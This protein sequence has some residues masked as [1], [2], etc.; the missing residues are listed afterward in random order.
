MQIF[1]CIHFTV[2]HQQTNN[3]PAVPYTILRG[4]IHE[5]FKTIYYRRHSLCPDHRDTSAF[6]IQLVRKQHHHRS[7]YANQR[8]HMG[9]YEIIIFSDAAVCFLHDLPFAGR[10][11]LYHIFS[12]CRNTDRNTAHPTAFPCLYRYSGQGLLCSGYR[13]IYC[14]RP[15]RLLSFLPAYL[16]LQSKTVHRISLRPDRYTFFLFY[17]VYLSSAGF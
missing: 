15:V 13:H 12:L 8:I 7:F 1:F 10:L 4:T 5:K 2:C 16:I 3:L 11:P 17:P 6:Y 14:E 9:A